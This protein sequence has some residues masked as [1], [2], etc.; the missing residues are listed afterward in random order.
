MTQATF[1]YKA[2]DRHGAATRG[3]VMAQ[4]QRDAYRQIVSSGLKPIRIRMA[5]RRRRNR[6]ITLRE[7]SQF[8]YQ[9][10]VLLEAGIPVV[11]GLRS[12]GEQETNER[13]REIVLRIARDVE[14]GRNITQ[15]LDPHRP[16]FGDVYVETVHAAESSG[17]L[18]E[19]MNRLA[20]MLESEQ[21]L[22]K[23]ARGALMYPMC[24]VV[25]L[26][27]ALTFLLIIIV[28]KFAGM[29]AAR[30]LDLPLPTQALVWLSAAIRAS[31]PGLLAGGLVGFMAL[32]RAWSRRESRRRIDAAL[33]R[34]P[35]LREL[36]TGLAIGRFAQVFG[37]ALRSG[38]GLIDAL[39]LAG[40]ASGRPLLEAD[41]AL[42]RDRVCGGHRLRDVI[43]TCSY[44]PPFTQRMLSAGEEA[45]DLTKM[46]QIIAR[47]YER[48]VSHLSRNI[49]TALE[50]MLIAGLA[51]IVLIVALA[52]F[53]PMWNMGALMG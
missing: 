12:I 7:I 27:L 44:F 5:A 22:R 1:Q 51:A 10:A 33:H 11:E 31:W 52:I 29:F 24:V 18:V 9:V 47:H 46:C 50:P 38:L 20:G 34:V 3:Q 41:V 13:L 4:D 39:S 25:A 8:T 40:K 14:G 16:V 17:N 36:L 6:R 15:S 43:A 45:A 48:E 26:V 2:L 49:A 28:P 30:G 37:I 42:M 53:L 23:T 35:F 32:R 21:E 19:V